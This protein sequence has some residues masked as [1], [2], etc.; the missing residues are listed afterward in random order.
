MDMGIKVFSPQA[1][2]IQD[3]DLFMASVSSVEGRKV[4]TLEKVWSV[5][6]VKSINTL[7]V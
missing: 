2:D 4:V 7:L 6:I 5:H 3:G 1:D